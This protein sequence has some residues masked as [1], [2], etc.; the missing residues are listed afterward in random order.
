MDR[1][2]IAQ[3]LEQAFRDI[4]KRKNTGRAVAV[5]L[6]CLPWLER[7]AS[8][9]KEGMAS[10]AREFG[11]AQ[12]AAQLTAVEGACDTLAGLLK[13][14]AP[15]TLELIGLVPS[16]RV[17]IENEQAKAL[18]H[19]DAGNAGEFFRVQDFAVELADTSSR[20]LVPLGEV[21]EIS[22]MARRL[23][24]VAALM[25][26][27][28][29]EVPTFKIFQQTKDARFIGRPKDTHLEQ[30][31]FEACGKVLLIRGHRLTHMKPIAEAVFTWSQGSTPSGDWQA[32]AFTAARGSVMRWWE[33][34]HRPA[35]PLEIEIPF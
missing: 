8:V 32:R 15:S 17:F 6:D 20:Y 28:Q 19:W 5:A 10:R 12:L 27:L 23:G 16:G 25:R 29:V 1:P 3:G 33:E 30:N 21:P 9:F 7:P 18:E 24:C 34:S 11:R 14:L 2:A 13:N 31:L 35:E 4:K 26:S 22:P